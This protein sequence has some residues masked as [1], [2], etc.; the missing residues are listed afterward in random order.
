MFN[1]KLSPGKI[2]SAWIGG[3]EEEYSRYL[4]FVQVTNEQ[5]DIPVFRVLFDLVT[6]ERG[7]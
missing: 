6:Y 3:T 7:A 5:F 2:F 4:Y 1:R